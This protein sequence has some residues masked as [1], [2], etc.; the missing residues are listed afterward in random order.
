[1][2]WLIFRIIHA[3]LIFGAGYFIYRL[4]LPKDN[5]MQAFF[6][7]YISVEEKNIRKKEWYINHFLYLS[8]CI[9]LSYLIEIGLKFI[10]LSH[11]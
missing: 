5:F 10:F 6:N 9:C 8:I 7:E 1:M 2:H 11:N 4:V 3:I